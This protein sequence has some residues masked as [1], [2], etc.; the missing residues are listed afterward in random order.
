MFAMPSARLLWREEMKFWNQMFHEVLPQ[1]EK[2]H[3]LYRLQST[4]AWRLQSELHP[5]LLPLHW[6]KHMFTIVDGHLHSLIGGI[7]Y[8]E[9][10]ENLYNFD[11]YGAQ[12]RFFHV[13]MCRIADFS[14]AVVHMRLKLCQTVKNCAFCTKKAWSIVFSSGIN[15]Q[16]VSY[17]ENVGF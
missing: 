8:G 12:N 11:N 9:A 17:I 7:E 10:P 13:L 2:Q 16:Q 5:E 1:D 14:C 6:N 4:G 15:G 3:W